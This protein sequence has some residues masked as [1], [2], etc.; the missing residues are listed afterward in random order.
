MSAL[1]S[2]AAG[3]PVIGSRTGGLPELVE[4]G[5]SGA[6]VEPGEAEP[7]A[8][9]LTAVLTQGELLS[10]L[11]RGALGAAEQFSLP[12]HLGRLE[13]LYR[14]VAFW[15]RSRQPALTGGAEQE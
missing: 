12:A 6:L 11:R 13:Q 7:L 4:D 3:V 10:D 5:V 2:L 8:E 14:E 9:A 15:G 1:E